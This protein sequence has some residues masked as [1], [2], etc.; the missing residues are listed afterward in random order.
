MPNARKLEDG[1]R[2]S[3][4]SAD[5]LLAN[6]MATAKTK[7]HVR[8]LMKMCHLTYKVDNDLLDINCE[9]RDHVDDKDLKYLRNSIINIGRRAPIFY[10]NLCA[11]EKSMFNANTCLL[12]AR[13]RTHK[14]RKFRRTNL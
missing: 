2:S 4:L 9:G 6:M 14:G 10:E 8:H 3:V 1:I 13:Q 12:Y 11:K 5:N 7:Q